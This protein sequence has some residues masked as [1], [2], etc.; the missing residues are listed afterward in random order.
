L[1]DISIEKNSG[2]I[3]AQLFEGHKDAINAKEPSALA[4]H[5]PYTNLLIKL[6]SGLMKLSNDEEGIQATHLKI[7][8]ANTLSHADVPVLH[9][10]LEA[11]GADS[12]I[13]LIDEIIAEGTVDLSVKDEGGT[14][15]LHQAC[16]L[17]NLTLAKK[18]LELEV[19]QQDTSP[20][21]PDHLPT[22]AETGG[23]TALA[24]A[25]SN[26]SIEM[27]ALLNQLHPEGFGVAAEDALLYPAILG[28]PKA[29]VS[30]MI[31][32]DVSNI[33]SD[34]NRSVL[35]GAAMRSAANA[36]EIAAELIAAGA[37]VEAKDIDGATPLMLAVKLMAGDVIQVLLDNAASVTAEAK[38]GST[39]VA[40]A[41]A[42]SDP[43]MQNMLETMM[44]KADAECPGKLAS[45]PK[46]V[47]EALRNNNT[48]VLDKLNVDPATCKDLYGE[49]GKP[50]VWWAAFFGHTDILKKWAEALP[51]SLAHVNE[52]NGRTLWH[53]LAIWGTGSDAIVPLLKIEAEQLAAPQDGMS[54]AQDGLNPKKIPLELAAMYGRPNMVHA[55]V[56]KALETK[57]GEKAVTE[58][59]LEAGISGYKSI[60]DYLN[61]KKNPSGGDASTAPQLPATIE[62]AQAAATEA[63]PFRDPIFKPCLDSLDPTGIKLK[64]GFSEI[65][66]ISAQTL[67]GPNPVLFGSKT[68][69]AGKAMYGDAAM[70]AM[71]SGI[72]QN[73]QVENFFTE[74][75]VSHTGY[76]VTISWEGRE[77]TV[78]IDDMIP[79]LGA[80]SQP[81]AAFGSVGDANEMWFHLWL[82]ALAKVAGGYAN[83][84]SADTTAVTPYT[85]RKANEAIPGGG[86]DAQQVAALAPML[87]LQKMANAFLPSDGGDVLAE[88]SAQFADAKMDD[89]APKEGAA[90]SPDVVESVTIL[91]VFDIE[92]TDDDN[93]IVSVEGIIPTDT[94][95]TITSA[96]G[97]EVVW[98]PVIEDSPWK[99]VNMLL[100]ETPYHIE[101]T[102]ESN[103][104]DFQAL[105]ACHWDVEIV[106]GSVIDLI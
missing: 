35:H 31:G 28:A 57:V 96:M 72:M 15:M 88:L 45:D 102:S 46:V 25:V 47:L 71:V 8:L 48:K 19:H 68:P 1:L 11:G 97:T 81:L 84:F 79:V 36:G 63:C 43:K 2:A 56:D 105:K 27:V 38:D 95:V 32:G 53:Y 101:V 78:L 26:G 18:L 49:P 90:V 14:T 92:L 9:K 60:E 76:N 7:E 75:A 100:A 58:A 33:S 16:I 73:I 66:W 61:E 6:A 37:D 83:I 62:D 12:L 22:S 80:S 86:A 91:P 64:D 30:A 89:I 93:G 87:Q 40:L 82:K 34:Y 21:T 17:D 94:K 104:D 10:V 41:L 59:M 52:E 23:R 4:L 13:N 42:S 44:D 54:Q 55:L 69:T 51:A 74:S 99:E 70:L 39:P 98:Q 50:L 67:C 103:E 24:I 85:Q 29:M 5:E 77:E 20:G 65:E 3:L 106:N